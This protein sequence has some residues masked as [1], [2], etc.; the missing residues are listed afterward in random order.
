MSLVEPVQYYCLKCG[1]A[2]NRLTPCIPFVN[3]R[4]NYSIFGKLWRKVWYERVSLVMRLFGLI[5]IIVFVPIILIGMPFVL[6]EKIRGD[7]EHG[8]DDKDD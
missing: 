2:S 3:I 4:Y 8:G 7:H 5:M 6:L 1:Q